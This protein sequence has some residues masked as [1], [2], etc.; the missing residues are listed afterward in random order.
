MR[1]EFNGCDNNKTEEAGHLNFTWSCTV[2]YIPPPKLLKC[3]KGILLLLCQG[4][5][6]SSTFWKGKGCLSF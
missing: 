6:A 3:I 4:K 5:A 1:Q 2:E